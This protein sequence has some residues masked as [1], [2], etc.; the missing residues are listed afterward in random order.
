MQSVGGRCRE[1]NHCPLPDFG[2]TVHRNRIGT[3]LRQDNAHTFH[4]LGDKG[5]GTSLTNHDACLHG[6]K[7]IKIQGDLSIGLNALWISAMCTTQ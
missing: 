1:G 5:V 4:K 7:P 3:Y 6:L 2:G